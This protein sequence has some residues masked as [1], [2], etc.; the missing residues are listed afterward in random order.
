MTVALFFR[1]SPDRL[2]TEC[3]QRRLKDLMMLNV[4]EWRRGRDRTTGD[5]CW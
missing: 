4:S 3:V 5:V 2:S 1:E